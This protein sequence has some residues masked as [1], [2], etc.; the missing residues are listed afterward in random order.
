MWVWLRDEHFWPAEQDG[1]DL[2]HHAIPVTAGPSAN[3]PGAWLVAAHY[4]DHFLL[5]L[6]RLGWSLQDIDVIVTDE[7]QVLRL[8]R[9]GPLGV[10]RVAHRA[11]T[12]WADALAL[13]NSFPP[14]S[15]L[16][17]PVQKVTRSLT[18][19]GRGCLAMHVAGGAWTQARLHEAGGSPTSSCQ[20]CGAYGSLS[21][22]VFHCPYWLARRQAYLAEHVGELRRLIRLS[23]EEQ[24]A[25]LL[26]PRSLLHLPRPP[27]SEAQVVLTGQVQSAVWYTDASGIHPSIPHLRLVSWSVVQLSAQG[28]PSFAASSLLPSDWGPN[29]SVFEGELY[30]IIWALEHAVTQEVWVYVDNASVVVGAQRSSQ[31]LMADRSPNRMLW[32]R[33]AVAK[34]RVNLQVIKIK[35]HRQRPSEPDELIPWLGNE[36]ADT[37][38]KQVANWHPLY[39]SHFH[40]CRT[41]EA[42]CALVKFVAEMYETG[43]DDV[44]FPWDDWEPPG[45]RVLVS[46]ASAWSPPDWFLDLHRLWGPLVPPPRWE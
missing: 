38:A 31:Q 9:L 1:P 46:R 39:V 20:Y 33:L 30:A 19:W 7:G 5:V 26:F 32:R 40:A 17:H 34:T 43:C 29:T 12:R 6:C 3:F 45:D 41:H 22:R 44:A 24:V 37:T 8:L 42:I 4:M 15:L 13:Q 28:T 11:T 18:T 14:T 35:A 27:E 21:H 23:S 36:C 16:W 10:K 2:F 25:R